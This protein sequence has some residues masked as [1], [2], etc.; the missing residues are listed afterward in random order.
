MS[1][2]SWFLMGFVVS[3]V[4]WFHRFRGVKWFRGFIGFVV[5]DGLVVSCVSRFQRFGGVN[6]FDSFMGSVVS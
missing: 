1:M 4:S 5:S 6:S 3:V 2:V